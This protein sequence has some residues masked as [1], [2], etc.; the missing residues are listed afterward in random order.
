M[1]SGCTFAPMFIAIFWEAVGSGLIAIGVL[2][3]GNLVRGTVELG[4]SVTVS[5]WSV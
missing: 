4:F 1:R 5:V 2:H 3:V